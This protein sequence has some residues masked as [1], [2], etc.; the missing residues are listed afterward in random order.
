MSPML[1]ALR[2]FITAGIVVAAIFLL[3][4]LRVPATRNLRSLVAPF[5]RF[6]DYFATM[7]Y[8]LTLLLAS[9]SIMTG[10]IVNT[11]V[12][13]KIGFL[14]MEAAGFHLVA[15]IVVAF[16][17]G[18]LL[19]TGLPPAPTYILTALVIGPAML[20][21][22]INP[23]VFHFFAFF[24]AVWGELT[25][26]T[27]VVAAVTSKIAEADFM[28][29]LFRGIQLCSVLF[30]LMG[31]VFARPEL[32]LEPGLAQ[33]G[34]MLLLMAGTVGSQFSLQAQF[35]E[36]RLLDVASR[37]VLAGFSLL[38]VFH[39]NT[40]LAALAILPVGI[41]IGYWLLQQRKKKVL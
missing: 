2:V 18:A 38:I 19:G 11:G 32:V 3:T 40:R 13:T 24:V 8:D 37:I 17:F 31:G 28:G 21:A 29:T 14:L 1:A 6:T 36:K 4:S 10:V 26:P 35:S 7:T 25:P 16:F 41:F 5:L 12:T 9:L 33:L 34:A 23:W 30:I 27:S 39:P 22:G 20:K 15:M